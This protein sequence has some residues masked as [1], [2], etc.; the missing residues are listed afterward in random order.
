MTFSI[1]LAL[2]SF[3]LA[4][5]G[6]RL[7]I[8]AQR[9]KIMPLD[10]AYVKT[11]QAPVA[12]SGGI[13]LV[14]SIIIGLLMADIG[15]SVVFS[16]L[17]LAAMALLSDL[18]DIPG[19][20]KW[21][22]QLLAIAVTLGSMPH[23]LFG[24]FLLTPTIDKC[25]TALLWLWLIRCF[26]ITDGLDGLCA[27]HVV[28]LSAAIVFVMAMAGK[29][30]GDMAHYGLILTSAAIGFL[31]WNWPPAKIMLG[32][33]GRTPLGFLIG[34]LLLLLIQQD[35]VFP[36]LILPAYFLSDAS[37]TALRRLYH[38]KKI[39]AVH[40]DHYYQRRTRFA[41]TAPAI[42][43]YIMGLHMLL[44]FL[45]VFSEL[46]PDIALILLA[47]AYFAV[48]MLLGFFAYERR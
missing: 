39:W 17:L 21:L 5:L 4:L 32:E 23:G 28:A 25:I 3:M 38:G 20:V 16:L 31:W 48:F 30:P 37:L 2:S 19:F 34:F 18:I 40:S 1:I 46:Q 27:S 47:L 7:S 41:T 24:D 35:H 43:R 29:F 8:L 9:K 11:R 44:A 42:I 22:V 26:S 12:R 6:T 14:F 13:V 45:A 36:A 15:Y 33:V 10:I